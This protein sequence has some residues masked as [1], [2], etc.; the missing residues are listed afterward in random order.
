MSSQG[1]ISTNSTRANKQEKICCPVTCWFWNWKWSTELLLPTS[2]IRVWPRRAVTESSLL[3]NYLEA[4]LARDPCG[5]VWQHASDSY[6]PA[7]VVFGEPGARC[8]RKADRCMTER[9]QRLK[10]RHPKGVPWGE[11]SWHV[12][13]AEWGEL[14]LRHLVRGWG[15]RR[16][17]QSWFLSLAL[18]LLRLKWK[19]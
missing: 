2:L 11:R 3:S 19:K 14:L 5:A 6:V 8:H 4:A 1:L 10:W 9:P 15:E 7:P 12:D 16:R 17:L 18:Y 13:R